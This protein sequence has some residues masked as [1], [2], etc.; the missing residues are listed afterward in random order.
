MMTDWRSIAAS[1]RRA[2]ELL[3]R[4]YPAG[5]AEFE[6]LLRANPK[7]GMLLYERGQ[8]LA[9]IGAYERARRDL[10]EAARRFPIEKYRRMALQALQ[11]LETA[12]GIPEEKRAPTRRNILIPSPA[13]LQV[14][15][16]LFLANELRAVDFDVAARLLTQALTETHSLSPTVPTAM[17]IQS[18]NFAYYQDGRQFDHQHFAALDAA[19]HGQRA[20]LLRFRDRAIENLSSVDRPSVEIVFTALQKV[21]GRVGAAKVLH[22][23]APR[24]FPLWDNPIASAYGFD[25]SAPAAHYWE[26]TLMTKV[27]AASVAP[28]VGV[29]PLKALDEYNY[30][31][32]SKRWLAT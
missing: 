3:K 17:L 8:A 26:F 28:P 7:D 18:W 9:A 14:A 1:A 4:D 12:P 21:V 16:E 15:H 31:R 2:A 10:E 5:E 32:F 29:P 22:L 6:R 25:L 11:R 20:I 13:D 27:Q 19:L 23:W 30:C 24:V